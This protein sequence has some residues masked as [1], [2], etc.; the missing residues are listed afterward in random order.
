MTNQVVSYNAYVLSPQVLDV[1]IRAL[2]GLVIACIFQQM[3][4]RK[5][6][7]STPEI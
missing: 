6:I 5:K 2:A 1:S 3:I 7:A 4:V